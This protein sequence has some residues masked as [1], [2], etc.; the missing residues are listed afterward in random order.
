M[1]L[2]GAQ[3][4]LKILVSSTEFWAESPSILVGMPGKGYTIRQEEPCECAYL[5]RA[6]STDSL[7]SHVLFYIFV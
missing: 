6:V 1:K 5:F 2:H 3:P 7:V 4:E